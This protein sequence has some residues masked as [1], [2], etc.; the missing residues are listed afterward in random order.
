MAHSAFKRTQL[1]D[2]YIALAAFKQSE[3][4]AIA[5]FHAQDP[6]MLAHRIKHDLKTVAGYPSL[7]DTV[8]VDDRRKPLPERVDVATIGS[9]AEFAK[10]LQARLEHDVDGR[11]E[12][13]FTY[14]ERE[15][16]PLRGSGLERRQMDLLLLSADGHPILGELKRAADNLPY[17]ALI[18][19]FVHLVELS[20][21]SQRRRLSTL[22]VP[23]AACGLPMDLYLIAYGDPHV[24]HTEASLEATERIAR[25]LMRHPTCGL[26][27]HVRR[28]VYLEAKPVAGSLAFEPTFV[29]D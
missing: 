5:Q 9:T 3:Q 22:G 17:Y 28:V 25:Q 11:S 10:A 19:L 6:S 12:L 23:A 13:R 4:V 24:T 1:R 16:S 14:L 27:E 7:A 26:R 20:S 2:L 18:Q 21:S 8:L 29:V 15:P